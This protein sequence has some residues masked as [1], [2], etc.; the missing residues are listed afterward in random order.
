MC[1]EVRG[2]AIIRGQRIHVA[3]DYR[4]V[5][6]GNK[7]TIWKENGIFYEKFRDSTLELG[8]E[9]SPVLLSCHKDRTLEL[10]ARI[11]EGLTIDSYLHPLE[12]ICIDDPYIYETFC[13]F[14]EE[15]NWYNL[16]SIYE[17]IKFDIDG[18]LGKF[19]KEVCNITKWAEPNELRDFKEAANNPRAEGRARHST[20]FYRAQKAESQWGKNKAWCE[21][22]DKMRESQ[23]KPELMSPADADGLI[24]RIFRRWCRWKVTGVT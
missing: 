19:D 12:E 9:I 4:P 15:P 22:K 16:Y 8:R 14:A 5:E 13:Y 7:I 18:H 23:E 2:G 10:D 6:N 21:Y 1:I 17:M 3:G 24:T 20:G 11:S